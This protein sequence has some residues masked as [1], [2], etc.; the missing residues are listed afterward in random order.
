MLS[1]HTDAV[2]DICVHENSDLLFSASADGTVKFWK[3]DENSHSCYHTL[4]YPSDGIFPLL[5]HTLPSF[6]Y[7]YFLLIII[8]WSSS[9][10]LPIIFYI[11]SNAHTPTTLCNVKTNTDSI[12]IGYNSS[13]ILQADIET[14]SILQTIKSPN[15]TG[16]P[17]THQQ[18]NQ[19]ITHP[20]L[21]MA[22]TAHEDRYIR[23]FDLRTGECAISMVAH[24]DS[25]SSLA[26][27][28]AGSH[29]FSGGSPSSILFFYA[30]MQFHSPF[31]N[32][33]AMTHL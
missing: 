18:I 12:L 3:F 22:F 13:V 1:G 16:S 8:L 17:N 9:V 33:Q 30:L 15:F 20:I 26:I 7:L 28:P 31:F 2:W 27:D 24:L 14:G 32:L 29:L 10:Y 6:L 19:I 11:A 25:V 4:S 5:S 21:P 23:Y